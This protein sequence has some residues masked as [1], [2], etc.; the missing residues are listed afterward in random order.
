[1]LDCDWP[2]ALGVNRCSDAKLPN[3]LTEG[4]NANALISNDQSIVL[5]CTM[6]QGVNQWAV[7]DPD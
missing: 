3:H 7:Q 2:R 4:V 6:T 5:N 1:M